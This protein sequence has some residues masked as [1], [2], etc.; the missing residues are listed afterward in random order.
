MKTTLATGTIGVM[1]SGA[2]IAIST[3]D[4]WE[5]ALRIASLVGGIVV[6]IITIAILLRK[7]R[8]D[9]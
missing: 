4:I 2:S 3:A 7:W 5:Q 1:A 6:T 9:E 8:K